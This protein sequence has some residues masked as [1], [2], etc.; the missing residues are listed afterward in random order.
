MM[1]QDQVSKI[2]SSIKNIEETVKLLEG[3]EYESYLYFH[4]ITIKTELKRQLTN[5]TKEPTITE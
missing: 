2:E 4:L 3:N 5:L 1:N